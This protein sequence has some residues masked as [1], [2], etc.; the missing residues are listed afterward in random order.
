MADLPLTARSLELLLGDWRGDGQRV[1]GARG[2]HPPAHR[3]RAHRGR[4]P[5]ACR[6]RPRRATRPQP[7][8]GDG[9]LPPPARAGLCCT[10]CAARAAWRGCRARRRRCPRRSR[11]STSTSP[12]RRR[13]RCR[14]CPRSPVRRVEDLPAH[15]ADAGFDPIGTPALRAAIADR[16][17]ARGLPDDARADHGDHRRAARHRPAVASARRARRPRRHRGADLPA[18]LRGAARGRRTARARARHAARHRRRRARGDREASCRPS[19]TR[20]PSRP[21]SSPTSRTRPAAP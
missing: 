9:L 14:G 13:P 18:R 12:R 19:A 4:H 17:T 6:A 10:A 1:R 5:A 2:A 20:T 7:H 3:R 8:H 21:T 16:Y 15:L 11:P